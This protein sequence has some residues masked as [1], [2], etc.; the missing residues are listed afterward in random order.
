MASVEPREGKRGTSYRIIVSCGLDDKGDQI[1]RTKTW[2][3]EP[4]MTDRQIKKTLERVKVDFEREVEK[5]FHLD[6]RQTFAEYAEY[7]LDQKRQEGLKRTTLENYEYALER[8][9]Q[10]IGHMRLSDILPHHLN[11]FYQTLQ[12][13]GIQKG[14]AYAV[15]KIDLG[16]WLKERN[17]TVTKFAKEAGCVKSTVSRVLHNK[18]V[19]LK[20]AELIAL[21]VG[22]TVEQCFDVIEKGDSPL[23]V[24]TI[25]LFRTAISIVLDKAE[26][27]MLVS[28]NAAKKSTTPKRKP[29][30]PNYFQP[31]IIDAILE[32]LEEEPL[33]WRLLVHLFIVTGCRR[34]ELLGLKWDKVDLQNGRITIERALLPGRR[35]PE[36]GPYE[37]T[38]KTGNIRYLVLPLESVQLLREYQQAQKDIRQILGSAWQETGYVFTGDDG[39]PMTPDSVNYWLTRFS[40][41]HGLPHI[42]P[43][44][45]R[46]TAAS[47]LIAEG[48]DIVT[49]SKLLGHS[50]VP[51]TEGIY[52]HLIEEKKA[53]AAKCI[54]DVLLRRKA[55]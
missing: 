26:K 4:G 31:D 3:P 19:Q 5:G 8:A 32:A 25:K 52:A 2:R 41:R 33:K 28:F 9:N 20:T 37:G 36:K 55:R 18:K 12:Q 43:H 46:H 47:I 21:A 49:V 16:A 44:A 39:R 27:D 22:K 54:A 35:G 6:A 13:E 45:F 17:L 14:S 34:G 1:K 50:N 10:A 23:S 29:S 38:T 48:I 51:T 15:L 11:Q 24:G 7:V 30:S 53:Q 40:I 42:N